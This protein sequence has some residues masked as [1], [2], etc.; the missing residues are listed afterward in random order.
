MISPSSTSRASLRTLSL[1]LTQMKEANKHPESSPK[2][3]KKKEQSKPN[4]NSASEDEHKG[5]KSKQLP[6]KKQRKQGNGGGGSVR[7]YFLK[8]L[9]PVV[10]IGLFFVLDEYKAKG[11]IFEPN[12]LQAVARKA[13]GNGNVTLPVIVKTIATELSEK[14]PGHVNLEEKWI[15]NNAGG[16]MVPIA[17]KFNAVI[18]Y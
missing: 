17:L 2:A 7:S 3:N 16:A 9:I 12:V 14:Y 11:Y 15:F 13:I 1:V 8:A 18:F 6:Q 10:L 4:N 5:A